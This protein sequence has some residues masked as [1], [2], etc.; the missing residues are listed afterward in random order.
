MDCKIALQDIYTGTNRDL[1]K[2]LF[3]QKGK[4]VIFEQPVSTPKFLRYRAQSS[5]SAPTHFRHP[6]AR[7]RS[8][9]H[10]VTRAGKGRSFIPLPLSTR[11]RSWILLRSRW[12]RGWKQFPFNLT[13]R[14]EEFRL[15]IDDPLFW[16]MFGL[17]VLGT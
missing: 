11:D 15:K 8:H 6:R 2:S 17:H 12:R 13:S 3:T 7:P 9:G 4:F 14:I 16:R 5:P 1:L 10:D